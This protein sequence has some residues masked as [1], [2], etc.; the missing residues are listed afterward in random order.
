[1][2]LTEP[3][4]LERMELMGLIESRA[5]TNA[6][7]LRAMSDE[8]LAEHLYAWDNSPIHVSRERWLDWLKSY[9]EEGK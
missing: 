1:M 7:R 3:S 9:A 6:D 8:E 4:F 2:G 5:V